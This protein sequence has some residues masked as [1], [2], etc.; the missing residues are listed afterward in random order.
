M[1]SNMAPVFGLLDVV[2]EVAPAEAAKIEARHA[3]DVA[4]MAAGALDG[5]D[6]VPHECQELA[7]ACVRALAAGALPPGDAG[8]P[9]FGEE[10]LCRWGSTFAPAVR[11]LDEDDDG[12]SD[13]GSDD[14]PTFVLQDESGA[15][16]EEM[17][18][19]WWRL[20]R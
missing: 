17:P 16:V 2:R 5:A 7:R 9:P 3:D 10:I 18:D 19:E 8:A 20:S 13:V 11:E 4:A 6:S 15:V 14:P 1:F 12:S